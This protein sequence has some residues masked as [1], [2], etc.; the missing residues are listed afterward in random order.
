M[1]AFRLSIFYLAVLAVTFESHGEMRLYLYLEKWYNQVN[2]QVA[3]HHVGG[4]Q[5]RINDHPCNKYE[6]S[7]FIGI[8]ESFLM[9]LLYIFQRKYTT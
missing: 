3:N 8:Y 1:E 9:L 5:Q 7:Y 6:K 2:F 4:Y